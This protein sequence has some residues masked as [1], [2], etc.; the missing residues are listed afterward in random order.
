M[1]GPVEVLT[2]RCGTG[3]LGDVGKEVRSF[4]GWVGSLVGGVS[5]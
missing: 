2:V 3:V 1:K 5:W 4:G